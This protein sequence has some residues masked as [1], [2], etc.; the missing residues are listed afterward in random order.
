V[1]NAVNV[2]FTIKETGTESN[3]NQI[4]NNICVGAQEG[5]VKIYG[6][7]SINQNNI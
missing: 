7:A 3:C 4:V 5:P 1:G 2:D 6:A